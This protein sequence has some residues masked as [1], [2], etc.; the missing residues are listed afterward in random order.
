MPDPPPVGKKELEP[1]RAALSDLNRTSKV[2]NKG[3]IE[4]QLAVIDLNPF[5]S[6]TFQVKDNYTL[7]EL[8]EADNDLPNANKFLKASKG[9]ITSETDVNICLLYTSPSPRD[10]G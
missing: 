8:Y 3:K 9:L 4:S 7:A 6:N 2:S 10:R 5:Q 1:V